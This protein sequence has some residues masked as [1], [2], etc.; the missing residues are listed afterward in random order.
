MM[1]YIGVLLCFERRINMTKS[2]G[3]IIRNSK[4]QQAGIIS[5]A[6][7][8]SMITVGTGRTLPMNVFNGDFLM[9]SLQ[10]MMTF[11]ESARSDVTLSAY[12]SDLDEY[13]DI[14]L[15]GVS[16]L[17][18]SAVNFFKKL[19]KK[20]KEFMKQFYAYMY[21]VFGSFDKFLVKYGS[22]LEKK[23]V[24][25]HV[26]GHTYNTNVTFP[27]L[28]EVDAV[29]A[30]YNKT[31]GSINKA[32]LEEIEK[33]MN[34]ETSDTNA[35]RVRGAIIGVGGIERGDFTTEVRKILRNGEENTG[36]IHITSTELRKYIA[37]YN[38]IKS[39]LR[40]FT[41]EETKVTKFVQSIIRVFQT[42]Y[43]VDTDNSGNKVYRVN[44]ISVDDR[45]VTKGDAKTYNI[46]ASNSKGITKYFSMMHSRLSEIATLVSIALSEKVK[47]TREELKFTE[48]IIRKSIMAG[49]KTDTV[50]SSMES[51]TTIH[52][53]GSY[54][55]GDI[56]VQVRVLSTEVPFEPVT[57]GRKSGV[58]Q[59]EYDLE[60]SG[61]DDGADVGLDKY[62]VFTHT[63]YGDGL[64]GDFLENILDRTLTSQQS[65]DLYLNELLSQ[66]STVTLEASVVKNTM[67]AGKS[68]VNKVKEFFR[69]IL[70]FI[71]NAFAR[72][73][74]KAQSFYQKDLAWIEQRE[75][76]FKDLDYNN[77]SVSLVPYWKGK[78]FNTS[79]EFLKLLRLNL[80][81]DSN[82]KFRTSVDVS[83]RETFKNE[84]L[85]PY[86]PKQGQLVDGLKDLMRVGDV[87]G[88]DDVELTG[89]NLRTR[90][91]NDIIPG[92]KN[93]NEDLK[94]L[95][96]LR[97]KVE[98]ELGVIEREMNRR[99]LKPN[100]GS[101]ESIIPTAYKT[102]SHLSPLYL[103]EAE[104]AKENKDDTTKNK[105]S[106]SPTN[107]SVEVTVKDKGVR[108]TEDK[109]QKMAQGS[110]DRTLQTARNLCHFI[111]LGLTAAMTVVEERQVLY[112]RT[113]RSIWNELNTVGRKE[114]KA[115]KKLA[116]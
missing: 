9:E 20:I 96:T 26:I 81:V 70:D 17:A 6:T 65:I 61:I 99:E 116:K 52:R 51:L 100:T 105:D 97:R 78:V 40:D 32:T 62:T 29:V 108:E 63:N 16:D 90:I 46:S 60:D 111:Q 42:G 55:E 18:K 73:K 91:M 59:D 107:K 57:A 41:K 2:F 38:D 19:L 23:N 13:D 1:W 21:S 14:M 7:T 54:D 84:L 4:L 58:T 10:E 94:N 48:K 109:A 15:E 47:A 68:G 110:D 93:Y 92:I 50:A 89:N 45:K 75:E 56:D 69:K 67:K 53:V 27:H 34:T 80:Y 102:L 87:N 11:F 88:S 33:L 28:G 74:E 77:I 71:K 37:N 49:E 79:D 30:S 12:L 83:D 24:D 106:S 112:V 43:R 72:F 113:C 103:L 95:D 3:S 5:K 8:E 104:D 36:E 115:D 66:N 64:A 39:R 82:N 35:N 31:V 22:E 101:L 85:K 25:F 86:V 98:A 44:E 114:S 76:Q